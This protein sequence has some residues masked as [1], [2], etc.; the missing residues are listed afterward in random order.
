MT[1]ESV[2]KNDQTENEK[3]LAFAI[4]SG[5]LNLDDVKADMNKKQKEDIIN[6]HPYSIWQGK[7]G[8]WRTHVS[9][10]TQK[11]GR[12]LIVKSTKEKLY[13]ALIKHYST[14][15]E[16]Q[17]PITLM[18]LYPQWLEYKGMHTQAET[19]ISRIDSDWKKYY[20]DTDII[21][22][23]SEEAGQTDTGQLGS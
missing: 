14:G 9:D 4:E 5:I 11:P 12:K 19:Y 10:D 3:L 17:D 23:P 8:R 22:I 7:D 6:K 21:R 20:L 18:V 13:E 16:S 1:K 15:A 2:V